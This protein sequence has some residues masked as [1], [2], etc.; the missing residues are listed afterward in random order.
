MDADTTGRVLVVVAGFVASG[1]STLSRALADRLGA[2]RLEADRVRGTLL[3]AAEAED[4]GPEARWRRD[5]SAD[6][7]D[8]IYA[9]LMRRAEAALENDPR[10]VL[11]ACFPRRAQR[12]AAREL[13]ARKQARFLVVECEV[14]EETLH[15]RLAERDRA[16][17]HPGWE[18]IFRQLAEH[19]EPPDELSPDEELEVR[20]DGPTAPTVDAIVARLGSLPGAARSAAQSHFDPQPRVV[21]FD[22]WSTLLGE[23][24][25]PWAHA[26]RVTALRDAAREAGCEVPHEI[27]ER[28]FNTAWQRHMALW[29]EGM[30][31]G[32]AEVAAWGLAEL[33]LD[34]SHPA[35]EHLV[36]RFEEASHTSHVVALD[37]AEALLS[38]LD[39]AGIPS[40]LV[41][42][43]GLTPGRV[44]RQ[45]LDRLGLLRYLRVQAFSDEVGAPKPDARA[46]LAAIGPL[47]V[48]PKHVLHV[49]DLKRTDVAGARALGMRTVRIRARHDDA[50]QMDDADD[51]VD[52]HAE[53][54]ALL[55][56]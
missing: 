41:C 56:L 42:D 49:G 18:A 47:G 17:G 37:G 2:I 13:A 5:L 36:R 55:G 45:L 11:D 19:F 27:A 46:F 32:S 30:V 38:A 1:K 44:V 52:S 39:T 22:C 54:A 40:V 9:D 33:G 34:D 15:S 50:T 21:S 43:T 31:S 3:E 4:A 48:D 16:A 6:F 8:E 14:P 10:V 20:G 28:A 7:E 53:L 24:D 25:W 12:V 29:E 51:I 26:L 35:L 23:E